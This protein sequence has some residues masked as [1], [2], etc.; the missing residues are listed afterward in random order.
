MWLRASHAAA[1]PA[2][3]R[4]RT[5]P[6]SC[7]V[8]HTHSDHVSGLPDLLAAYPDA[9]VVVHEQEAS[10]LTGKKV[11]WWTGWKEQG[12]WQGAEGSTLGEM[13]GP[14]GAW[15]PRSKTPH[16][17]PSPLL[18]RQTFLEEPTWLIR[19]MQAM[20]IGNRQVLEAPVPLDRLRLLRAA[21]SPGGAPSHS[22]LC[23]A[24]VESLS[25]IATLGHSPGHTS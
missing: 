10:Y 21:D 12:I 23:E 8:T 14:R 3:T 2:S 20:G 1:A 22:T 25:W 16:P 11:R 15:P 6:C 4:S 13:E 5:L 17:G 24:G 9:A 18:A 19:G 7:A